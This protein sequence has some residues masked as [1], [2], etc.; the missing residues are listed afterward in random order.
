MAGGISI[1]LYNFWGQSLEFVDWK[2]FEEWYRDAHGLTYSM[3]KINWADKEGIKH[4]TFYTVYDADTKTPLYFPTR[5]A[6]EKFISTTTHIIHTSKDSAYYIVQDKNGNDI[7][8]DNGDTKFFTSLKEIIDA[9]KA[10]KLQD[11]YNVSA[12]GNENQATPL[13]L[14]VDDYEDL[15]EFFTST[16]PYYDEA[17]NLIATPSPDTGNNESGDGTP[18][19]GKGTDS[20]TPGGEIPDSVDP[21]TG[22][23]SSDNKEDSGSQPEIG[24]GSGND[25]SNPTEGTT[26]S[27]SSD[28][29]VEDSNTGSTDSGS[30]DNSSDGGNFSSG[31]DSSSSG[32]GESSSGSDNGGDT[33]SSPESTDSS[34]DSS[35]AQQAPVE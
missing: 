30:T 27:G 18:S 13:S 12:F 17:G 24:S 23:S 26:D 22:N 14:D 11:G 9:Q 25:S 10:G 20:L 5:D 6:M 21:S 19:A 34:T 2:D 7:L 32:S 1:A 8:D 4:T 29:P 28:T 33:S 35:P 16:E 3:D 15:G 31:D